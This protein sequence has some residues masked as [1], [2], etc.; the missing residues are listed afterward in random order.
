M[1]A[2][3][4]AHRRAQFHYASSGVDMISPLVQS[5][6]R[7]L[8][9]IRGQDT[10]V[11]LIPPVF[12]KLKMTAGLPVPTDQHYQLTDTMVLRSLEVRVRLLLYDAAVKVCSCMNLFDR[13]ITGPSHQYH[14]S[15]LH[16]PSAVT[17]WDTR[18]L[19]PTLRATKR[20]GEISWCV[21]SRFLD[22]TLVRANGNL[23]K[24]RRIASVA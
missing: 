2:A 12:S 7:H 4:H 14:C 1:V 9:P 22:R 15:D 5:R 20:T 17:L 13:P 19:L 24:V 3:D 16:D 6:S 10:R 11:S 18:F 8:L 23:S 21:T